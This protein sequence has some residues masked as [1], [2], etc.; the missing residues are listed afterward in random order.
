MRV[1]PELQVKQVRS[2]SDHAIWQYVYRQ[3]T[4]SEVVETET[5]LLPEVQ[6]REEQQSL[7]TLVTE[8]P[9]AE[10]LHRHTVHPR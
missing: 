1:P 6:E 2:A 5:N 8:K 10:P 7:S 9:K 3:S 4:S